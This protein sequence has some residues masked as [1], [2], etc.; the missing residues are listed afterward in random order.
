M[1]TNDN[2]KKYA[3]L[4][5]ML[6]FWL[7]IKAL[8]GNKVDKVTGMGLS[9]NDLTDDLVEKIQ[10]AGDSSFTG[11][12]AD[13]TGKPSVNGVELGATNTLAA[14]GIQPA[15]NYPTEAEVEAM[16]T[17]L[18]NSA[19]A[20]LDTL[21]E[22]AAALGDDPNFATTI[23]TQMGNKVDESDLIEITNAEID[24]ILAT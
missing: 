24:T 16:I 10:N 23:A 7:K 13:L 22:L 14:L 1:A 19:P 5:T 3:G 18:V 21:A 2:E 9:H 17:S 20:T 6:Y 12:Y 8:L 11:A 15:G 4:N